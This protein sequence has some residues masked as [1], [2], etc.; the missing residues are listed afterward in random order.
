[1]NKASCL[2]IDTKILY[3]LLEDSRAIQL[4]CLEINLHHKDERRE[5]LEE[6]S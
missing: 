4:M 1:M 2:A 3:D 6:H 5:A